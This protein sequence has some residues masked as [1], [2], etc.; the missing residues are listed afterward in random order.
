MN[1][2]Y[3]TKLTAPILLLLIAGNDDYYSIWLFILWILLKI[4]RRE[5]FRLM[6]NSPSANR[7]HPN[8]PADQKALARFMSTAF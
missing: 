6:A 2:A 1:V 5:S 8:L 7:S 4:G 3:P